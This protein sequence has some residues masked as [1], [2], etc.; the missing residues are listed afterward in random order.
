MNWQIE[1]GY[2]QRSQIEAQ[3]SRWK[4]VFSD[5]L[6]ARDFDRQIAEVKIA[7]KA[8]NRMT[9]LGRAEYERVV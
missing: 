7:S 3:I 5:R 8:L 1:T 4:Q 6:Q 2:N 9:S